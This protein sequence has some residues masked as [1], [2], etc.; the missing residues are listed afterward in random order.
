MSTVLLR[1]MLSSGFCG[2][3]TSS[4]NADVG[5]IHHALDTIIASGSLGQY[6]QDTIRIQACGKHK[7]PYSEQVYFTS[8]LENLSDRKDR[9]STVKGELKTVEFE[10]RQITFTLFFEGDAMVEPLYSFYNPQH[11]IPMYSLCAARLMGFD[12]G[13][14]PIRAVSILSDY[15]LP[16]KFEVLKDRI[17]PLLRGYLSGVKRVGSPCLSC[18]IGDCSFKDPFEQKALEM[19][20]LKQ[21]L[22]EAEDKIKEHL[23]WHGPTQCGAHLIY[24]K[25]NVRRFFKDKRYQEFLSRIMQHDE[26]GFTQYLTPDAKDVFEAIQAGRLPKELAGFFTES[27]YHKMETSINM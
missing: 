6:V 25:E 14:V 7:V 8:C 15:E 13:P 27:R 24:M 9:F 16:V 12:L 2:G 21:A 11:F 1:H 10:G 26:K 5:S 17:D 22:Q 18:D 23:T 20:K 3:Y 4:G 19:F